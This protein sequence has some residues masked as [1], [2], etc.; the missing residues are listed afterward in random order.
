MYGG[1]FAG[2]Q[3]IRGWCIRAFGLKGKDGVYAFDF[4]ETIPDH[5]AYLLRYNEAL[6]S[7]SLTREDRDMLIEEKR[8]IFEMNE[9][10]FSELRSAQ[11]YRRR[12]YVLLAGIF[13]ILCIVLW[14]IRALLR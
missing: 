7:L 2:G 13:L 14:C 1:M 10:L 4:S 9:A 11:E 3:I 8:H 5:S 12:V 6:N